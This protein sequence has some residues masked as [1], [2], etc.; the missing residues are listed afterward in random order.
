MSDHDQ[1]PVADTRAAEFTRL[2]LDGCDRLEREIGYRPTRFR[3]MVGE[4][5]GVVAAKQLL[6]GP[7]TSDGFATL[8]EAGRLALSVE[9]HVLLPRFASVFSP[10]ERR[11]ARRRLEQHEFDVDGFLDQVGDGLP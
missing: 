3:Q 7:A 10:I 6:S 8:W 4:L 5:G 1:G 11:T 2:M 9:A